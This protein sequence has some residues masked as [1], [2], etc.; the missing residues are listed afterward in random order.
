MKASVIFLAGL[1]LSGC[2]RGEVDPSKV[3]P[4]PAH[5]DEAEAAVFE[6]YSA[7]GMTKLPTLYWY[8]GAALDC[9]DGVSFNWDG[10]CSDATTIDDV[11]IILSDCGAASDLPLSQKCYSVPGDASLPHEMAHALS[12]QTNGD[13]CE[14]HRCPSFEPGGLVEQATSLLASLGM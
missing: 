4:Q 3:V 2:G 7:R 9:A 14:D 5:A 6:L 8:G 11:T 12:L 1:A 10:G 13:G